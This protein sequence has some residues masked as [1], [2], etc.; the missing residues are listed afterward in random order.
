MTWLRDRLPST[1]FFAVALLLVQNAGGIGEIDI[2][3]RFGRPFVREHGAEDRVNYQF[4]MAARAGDVEILD[5]LLGHKIILRLF[6]CGVEE[7]DG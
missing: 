6:G 4:R 1:I 3:P 5:V 7:H 2:R